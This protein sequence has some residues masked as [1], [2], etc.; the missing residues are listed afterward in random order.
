MEVQGRHTACCLSYFS[1]SRDLGA[2]LDVCAGSG[3][4]WAVRLEKV[5]VSG[6]RK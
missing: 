3:L 1:S 2:G 6:W 5:P 4:R